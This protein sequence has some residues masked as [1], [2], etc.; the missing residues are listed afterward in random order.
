MSQQSNISG[1]LTGNDIIINL[2]LT[3]LSGSSYIPLDL[4]T[5]TSVTAWLKQDATE[6][7]ST[8][9]SYGVGTGLTVV[10]SPLGQL[11][12]AI[13]RSDVGLRRWYRVDVL[14]SASRN[15]TSVYGRLII[16]DV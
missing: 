5:I 3:V 6:P 7:D 16:Q 13:P 4:S 11:T 1:L 8:G 15:F 2:A 12:W 9:K 10:S 14:D